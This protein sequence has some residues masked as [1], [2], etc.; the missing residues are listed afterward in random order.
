M[1]NVIV[2]NSKLPALYQESCGTSL[3][4]R[5]ELCFSST[6]PLHML[7]WIYRPYSLHDI[8]FYGLLAL[9][10]YRPLS[11]DSIGRP[12]VP[13]ANRAQVTAEIWHQI[14]AICNYIPQRDIQNLYDR[15]WCVW[16]HLA[17]PE[18]CTK[19]WFYMLFLFYFPVNWILFYLC[20]WEWIKFPPF[21]MIPS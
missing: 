6:V 7:R 10:K 3:S 16:D 1:P 15:P 13:T 9:L 2:W 20:K 8:S 21:L 4:Q 17:P 5:I 11:W 18:V 14:E 12:L 19:Y